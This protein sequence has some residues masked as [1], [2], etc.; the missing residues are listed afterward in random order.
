LINLFTSRR[1]NVLHQQNRN[2]KEL[3]IL[4][5]QCSELSSQLKKNHFLQLTDN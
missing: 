2:V 4:S 3:F 5:N 1:N